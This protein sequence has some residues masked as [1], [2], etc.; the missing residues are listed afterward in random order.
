MKQ[1]FAII[2]L[3]LNFNP[4]EA[5]NNLTLSSKPAETKTTSYKI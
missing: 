1:A 3:I 5:Q 4:A 2:F